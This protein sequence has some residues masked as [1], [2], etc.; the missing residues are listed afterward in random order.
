MLSK[1]HAD[2]CMQSPNYWTTRESP[3]INI[4]RGIFI[5]AREQL[6]VKS[7]KKIT[8]FGVGRPGLKF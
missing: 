7:W 4:N 2:I 3:V 5:K 8:M 6:V 1:Y